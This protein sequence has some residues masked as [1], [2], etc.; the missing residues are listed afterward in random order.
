MFHAAG[1][2]NQGFV[3][4]ISGIPVLID[5]NVTTVQGATTNADEI[6][7]VYTPDFYFLEGD[8]QQVAYEEVLSAN[9]EIR[10]QVWAYSF[11]VLSREPTAICKIGGT[12]LVA[13]S[14]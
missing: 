3:G 9:L 10:L 5:P 11:L 13:P 8:V 4:S 6:Y 2:Q 1:E 12:G 14:F 7:V